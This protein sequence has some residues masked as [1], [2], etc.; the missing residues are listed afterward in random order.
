MATIK[1]SSYE[2]THIKEINKEFS[3]ISKCSLLGKGHTYKN[4]K[5]E[6]EKELRSKNS[7]RRSLPKMYISVYIISPLDQNSASWKNEVISF[8]MT[9]KH[10]LLKRRELSE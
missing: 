8:L 9:L 7:G 4:T 2:V 5:K 3:L 1:S 6:E 10:Y